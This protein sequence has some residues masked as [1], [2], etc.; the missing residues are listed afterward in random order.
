[1]RLIRKAGVLVLTL[2][3]MAVSGQAGTIDSSVIG[4]AL[5]SVGES[6]AQGPARGIVVPSADERSY[7]TGEVLISLPSSLPPAAID[8]L[9]RRHRLTRSESQAVGLLGTTVHRWAIADGRS[10]PDVILDLK[11]D[12][13]RERG[14]SSF[15]GDMG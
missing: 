9:A 5:E 12:G 7:R 8:A 4:S 1:M 6:P 11:R 3:P 13:G 2:M 10:I 15:V 14:K